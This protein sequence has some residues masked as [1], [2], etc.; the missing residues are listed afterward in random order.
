MNDMVKQTLLANVYDVAKVTPL[1]KAPK[2]SNRHAFDIY[3]K[4]ED[5]QPVHS[6]KLR[7][8]YNKISQLSEKDRQKGVIAASAG[9]HAQG[10]ALAAK[11]LG[12]SALVVMPRTTPSIKVDAVQSYGA[13]VELAGDSYTEAFEYAEKRI[14]ETGR[15]FVHPFDDPLVIAGQGTIG[16]EILEQLPTATHIFV[17]VGGGGLIAGIAQYAKSLRPDIKIIAVQSE[18][19]STVRP[20]LEEKQRVYLPQVGIFADGTAVKQLGEHT[21]PIIEQLVDDAVTVTTDEL[22]AAIKAIFEDTRAIVEPSGA[23]ATAGITAYA[24]KHSMENAVGVAICSGANISFERLQYVAERTLIGS[25][26]EAIFAVTMPERPGAL[27][28]FCDQVVSGHSITEFGYRLQD[29]S[30]AHIFVG[31]SL[32][33]K[34][35]K[36][37][38]TGKMDSFH[39]A[40]SDLTYDDTAKEHVRYMIGGLGTNTQNEHLYEVSFPERP[41]ALKDFLHH[42]EDAWN[43]SLFHYRA[44]GSDIGRVLIGFEAQDSHELEKRLASSTYEFTPINSIAT[45]IFLRG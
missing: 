17:P 23:L 42:L 31:I 15:V 35:E 30:E 5:L 38:L 6:F 21:F 36:Q 26:K 37:V 24:A 39:Y 34:E 32:R 8:A 12:I 41:G 43:I 13:L 14:Q 4:R 29:R 3:L 7:G 2:L 11:Q 16:R 25:D 9:N 44:T 22:C 40:Y 18:D 20:L 19:A 10:V 27:Q 28:L 33:H 45:S 1:K